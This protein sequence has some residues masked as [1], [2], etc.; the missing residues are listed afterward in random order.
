M[1]AL[2]ILHLASFSGNI[3]DNFNHLG[4]RPWFEGMLGAP[5]VW[6]DLEM[7]EFYWRERAWDQ[8][9]VDLINAHDVLVVGGGNYFEL[10]VENSPTGVSF[11]LP[12]ELLGATRVPVFFN[13]LGLDAGQ[14]FGQHSLVRFE[15]FLDFVLAEPRFLVS[16]RNDG[17]LATAH[18]LLR[19]DQADRLLPVPDAGFFV[20]EAVGDELNKRERAGIVVN[21]ACDMPE[22][23]FAAFPSGRAQRAFAEEMAGALNAASDALPDQMITFVAHVYHDLDIMADVIR[24]MP[25]RLRR[26][27]VSIASFGSGEPA[28]K[29]ALSAYSQASAVLGMRFHANI[30][31]MALGKQVVGLSCYP[32]IKFLYEEVGQADRLADVSA[33]GFADA[34]VDLTVR[35]VTDPGS[36]SGNGDDAMTR[37]RAQRRASEVALKR[38]IQS[39]G[40]GT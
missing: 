22:I 27:R 15:S 20:G 2:R 1:G 10:W 8:S 28:A 21:L 38:W 25:D 39:A 23:R 24:C 17:S 6:T 16:L 4:F 32:Q 36:F 3:G 30:A 35:A 19:K 34:L 9:F 29:A 14:G 37:V 7:R 26:T 18:R 40:I 13:A 11:A 31:A 12:A 33:S 5:A